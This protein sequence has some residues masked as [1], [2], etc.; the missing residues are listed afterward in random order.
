MNVPHMSGH[1]LI[2]GVAVVEAGALYP[3]DH[4]GV[5]DAEKARRIN[6]YCAQTRGDLPPRLVEFAGCVECGAKVTMSEG[7]DADYA[8]FRPE[9][10]SGLCVCGK[11]VLT[12][13]E[14]KPV[15]LKNKE[16]ALAARAALLQ[17]KPEEEHAAIDLYMR[18][19]ATLSRDELL[20]LA[21]AVGLPSQVASRPTHFGLLLRLRAELEET[22]FGSVTDK[23]R[24]RLKILGIK[25]GGE[26]D[27]ADS[28]DED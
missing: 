8:L 5:V 4:G 24:I 21:A 7:I 14:A 19:I 16:E 28:G 27:D 26:K 11:C 3:R 18:R 9:M 12:N 13:K 20:A 23:Q 15:S 17:S 25:R 2:R 10:G 1:A 6:L 22:M